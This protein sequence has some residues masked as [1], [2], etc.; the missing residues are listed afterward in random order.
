MNL[1]QRL[2]QARREAGLSQVEV[3]AQLEVSP[4]TVAGWETG[5]HGVRLER[6]RKI[7]AVLKTTVAKLVA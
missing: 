7:A 6:L 2:K 4:S 5:A 3:A 1:P